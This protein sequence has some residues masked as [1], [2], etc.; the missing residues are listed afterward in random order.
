MLGKDTFNLNKGQYSEKLGRIISNHRAN[1]KIIGEAADFVLRSCRLT[2]Q[3]SKM[4]NDPEV[5]VHLRNIEIAG[6]RKI[7]MLS[8]ERGTTKQPV[9]K[10]KLIDSLYPTKR[11][12]TSATPEEK[13]F[14]AVKASMRNAVSMQLKAYRDT[15]EL[16]YACPETGKMIRPGMR[17]DVDHVGVSFSEIADRFIESKGLT[18]TEIVLKGPPTA[19]VFK[20]QKL[21]AEWTAFH[22]ANAR[23][24][25][26]CASANRAK[27]A[28]GYQTP[29]ALY[30]TFKSDDPEVVS[31]DF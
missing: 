1:S 13:H 30:G 27:G 16:P 8:L 28:S 3:W 19:K 31:L 11:I 9:P 29:P 2:D 5:K 20:D 15:V 10:Q 12:A 26:V 17:S 6:G 24:A 25:L 4:A 14:N 21:W 23:F 22:L 7:K 18:Y